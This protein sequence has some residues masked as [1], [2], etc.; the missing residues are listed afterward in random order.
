MDHILRVSD[1][2]KVGRSIVSLVANGTAAQ[3]AF[4]EIINPQTIPSRRDELILASLEYC[5]KDTL[6]MVE[7][8]K[9]LFQQA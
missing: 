3:R 5:K 9:W 1:K 7:L 2:F 4:E 8:V 6:V